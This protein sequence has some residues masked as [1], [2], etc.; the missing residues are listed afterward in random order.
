M[1]TIHTGQRLNQN[2]EKSDNLSGDVAK[3]INIAHPVD[4]E[5]AV[6]DTT[7]P[8]NEISC[9][10][11]DKMEAAPPPD[12]PLEEQRANPK[13]SSRGLGQNVAQA[14]VEDTIEKNHNQGNYGQGI[15]SI[16]D[17]KEKPAAESL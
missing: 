9:N 5:G 15:R 10:P 7:P 13:D 14:V 2:S 17:I 16:P 3:P 6:A 4:S 8:I 1:D 12:V 11:G